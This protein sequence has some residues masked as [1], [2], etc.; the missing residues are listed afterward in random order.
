V[1]LCLTIVVTI[2]N[3]VGPWLCCC[4]FAA[5][6]VRPMQA[7][8][9]ATTPVSKQSACPHCRTTND[10]K[11]KSPIQKPAEPHC[12]CTPGV[13]PVIPDVTSAINNLPILSVDFWEATTIL[14]M[15]NAT[16]YVNIRLTPFLTSDERVRIHH[17]MNC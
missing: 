4:A 5:T 17:V 13:T 7:N 3:A 2:T 16:V 14:Q 12:N 1:R 10:D 9:H 8:P 6:I 11:N 15:V